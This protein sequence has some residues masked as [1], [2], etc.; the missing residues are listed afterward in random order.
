MPRHVFKTH[1]SDERRFG[2]DLTAWSFLAALSLFAAMAGPFFAGR[3]YTADDLGEFHLPVRA[4]YAEQMTRGEAHDWMPTLY[5]GFYLTGEGQAG[6]YH[7]LHQALYRFLPLRAALGLECLLSYP[8]MMLGTWLLLRRRLGSGG[9]AALGAL[10]F[11]FSSFNLLHFVHPNGVAVIAHVPWLLWGIDVVLLDARRRKVALASATIALLTGSQLLLGY[12]QF[13][14]LSLLAEIA[15]AAFLLTAYRYA[16]RTGCDARFTCNEC[17]GCA[18]QTWPRL[19]IAKG[20]G[21]LLGGVQLLP[22]LDAWLHSARFSAERDYF[23]WGSLH[24]MNLLQLVAPYLFADRVVGDSTHE[25]GLYLGAAPFVL[26]VWTIIRHREWSGLA[27]LAWASL[28]FGMAMLLLAFGCFGPLYRAITWLPLVGA[29]RFPCRY[30]VLFQLAATV[31]AAI[32]FTLLTNESR[33]AKKNR[34]LRLPTQ[35]RRP[36]RGL[37]EDFEPL[38]CVVGFSAAVAVVGLGLR[39][40]PDLGS[41]AAILA[42]P[43]LI[44][45]AVALLVLAAR[46]HTAAL[47]GLILF[48]AAD[49]GF[50]GLSYSVYPRNDALE[51]YVASSRVPPGQT[52]GRVVGD[53]LRFDEAG[54]RTGNSMILRGWARADGYS[55]LAPGRR[56][57][58]RLLPA[59]RVA[60]VHWVNKNRSTAVVAGLKPFDDHWM[61]VPEP[62]NRVR[63]VSQTRTSADPAADISTINP[64]VTALVEAPLVLPS[65]EPGEVVLAE[66]RPGRLEIDVD[67][68]AAQ[69]LVVAESH[70]PGWRATIDGRP[71]K[72]YRVNGDFIGCLTERGKHRVVLEFRPRSL[73]RG[74][75]ASLM[76]LCLLSLCFLG[77]TVRPESGP[78]EDCQ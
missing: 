56:L 66:D 4:F 6:V 52:E 73:Q 65:S 19:V 7:P 38:W 50:Y 46:G 63:L 71:C 9:A 1:Y 40:Q 12:P 24:P 33:L 44:G 42:G 72:V 68:P 75:T 29:F 26:V 61:R 53:L 36:W 27:R 51:N 58:Y 35:R 14:W 10:L 78:P 23:V 5:S 41:A 2:R 37:W 59:L 28:G 57:D 48:A 77:F 8:L 69:L 22:T 17:V 31:M 30:L 55:G 67:C 16:A 21:L 34:A 39:H 62:L 70:H 13:V 47:V 43:L 3:V 15:F 54:F 18:A 74:W 60:G 11:A 20:I 76:G 32:G 45:A 49:L 64:N 25:Y